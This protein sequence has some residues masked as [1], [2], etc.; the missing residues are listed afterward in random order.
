MGLVYGNPSTAHGA[1]MEEKKG[2]REIERGVGEKGQPL[3]VFMLRCKV[4][5]ACQ[6]RTRVKSETNDVLGA[7]GVGRKLNIL[8]VL[9]KVAV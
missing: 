7:W 1:P 3:R 2:T 9:V 4:C 5:D 8:L 6:R